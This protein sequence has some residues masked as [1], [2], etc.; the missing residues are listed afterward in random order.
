MPVSVKNM[1]CHACLSQK[2]EMSCLSQSSPSPLSEAV[3]THG[4]SHPS[5]LHHHHVEHDHDNNGGNNNCDVND[6]DNIN[7]N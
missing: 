1:K 3:S 4:D 7:Q 5:H 2:Y 6:G